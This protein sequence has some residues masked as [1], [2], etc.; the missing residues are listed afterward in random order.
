MSDLAIFGGPMAIQFSLSPYRTIGAEEKQAVL[1]VLDNGTLSQFL[2]AWDPDFYG[3]PK[4][5][6]FE[7]ACAKYFGVRHAITVNSWTS[8]LI[9]AVGAIGVEPG[10][11]VILPSWTMTASAAAVLHWGGI[12]IFADIEEESFCLTASSV[13]AVISSRTVA[14]MTVDIFG[15]SANIHDIMELAEKH[16]LKVIC[17]TAQAP[18]A[19]VDGKLAG[20]LGHIGGISLNYH[21]HIHTGEGGV[22]FTD[23]DVLAER[24]NLIRN[25]GEAVVQDMGVTRLDNIVGFNFRLGEIECAIGIEQLRKLPRLISSRQRAA[26]QL[27]EALR[28]LDG[29]NLPSVSRGN[30]HVYYVYG[31]VLSGKALEIGR[32]AIVRALEAEGVEGLASGYQNLHLLPTYQT[33]TAFGSKGFP[34]SLFPEVDYNY[35]KGICPTSERLH[36]HSFIGLNLCKFEYSHDEVLQVI[37]AFTKVWANLHELKPLS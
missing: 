30:T 14:I 13:E 19:L 32:D 7:Q 25:H 36:D 3:G 6:E 31:M 37:E 1:E 21:K 8:G 10:D 12:P 5:L 22:I 27:N 11:E 28:G 2:G 20:T 35:S 34:W 9:A 17:D 24:I 15:Q 33:K 4:V 26:L 16:G 29:L 18:G 23:D